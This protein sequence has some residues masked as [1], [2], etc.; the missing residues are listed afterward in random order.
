MDERQLKEFLLQENEKFRQAYEE[1]QRLEKELDELIKKGYLTAAEELK[2]K[3]LKK[4]K[5]AL[6]DQMYMIMENYRKKAVSE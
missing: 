6:K 2:E 4:R 1:H 3:Q 5:L